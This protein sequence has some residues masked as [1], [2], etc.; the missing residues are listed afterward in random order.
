MYFLKERI[1][2]IIKQLYECIYVERTKLLSLRFLEGRFNRVEE[3]KTKSMREFGA[4]EFWGGPEYHGWFRGTGVCKRND[5]QR[6]TAVLIS[7]DTEGWDVNNPQFL[8]FINGQLRQGIDVNHQ[9]AYVMEELVEGESFQIDL[10]A[11]S[12]FWGKRCPIQI[13]VVEVDQ[14]T[15]K[16]YLDLLLAYQAAVLEDVENKKRIDTLNFLNEAVNLLDLRNPHNDSYGAG[17]ENACQYV[18]EN[19]YCFQA[20]CSCPT[21]SCIGHTHIDVAWLW[22][23]D[24]TRDK[25]VRS[26]ST[27]LRLME[28][29]PE[30]QF[31]SSQP[32][33]YSFL[34]VDYPEVY[35][36][37]CQRVREG[38][39]E[40]EGSMWVEADCN[41]PSGE[42]LV[43]QI[44]FGKKFFK[45]EFGKDNRILW[46]P[47]VFGYSAALP[48]IMKKSGIDYF[49]TTKISWNQY[50]QVPYDTFM[51]RGIDGSEVL[52]HFITTPHLSRDGFTTEYN[53][54][55]NPF[56][57]KGAWT[58]YQQKNIN[59]DVLVG[60]GFGDGG[61]GTTPLM[62]ENIRRLHQGLVDCPKAEQCLAGEYFQK[63]ENTVKGNRFLPHWNGELYFELHRGSL[64]SVGKNKR[65]NRK[66]E[67]LLHE[68][69]LLGG[70]ALCQGGDY[71]K[72]QVDAYWQTLLLNQFHDIIPGT[73]IEGVYQDSDEQY[74][75]LFSSGETLKTCL[76]G[77]LAQSVGL[78]KAGVFV[79]NSLS[80]V[81]TE[82]ASFPVKDDSPN[83]CVRNEVGQVAPCQIMEGKAYFI[84]KD[85]PSMG[86]ATYTCEPSLEKD[87]ESSLRISEHGF[88][89]AVFI[90]E[91]D[92][93]GAL[94]RLYD[95]RAQRE[96]LQSGGKGNRLFAYE[97]KPMRW[98]NW[99]VDI[100]HLEK[101]WEVNEQV[102]IRV[103]E[104]GPVFACLC[105]DK[106]FN[107]STIHQK[108]WI[109]QDIPR[110][111][112]ETWVDWKENQILLKTEFDLNL[113]FSKASFDIQ[114][115]NIERSSHNN[116]SWDVAQFEVCGHKW[117]DVSEE[118]YGVSLLNDCK[119]GHRIKEGQMQLSLIKSGNYPNKS[120]DR[121][122]HYFT[123]S[124]FPHLETWRAA[125]TAEQAHSLN[126]PLSVVKLENASGGDPASASFFSLNCKNVM[127]D[128]VKPAENGKGLVLRF[129]EYHN[130]TTRVC[131]TYRLGK[132]QLTACDLL[133]N[134]LE[135]PREVEG[136]FDFEIKPYE[137]KTFY[138][139]C[140]S[141]VY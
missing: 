77:K 114:F 56:S 35:Q 105:V 10:K 127:L 101:G 121:E 30:Y 75:K 14:L 40:P 53:G 94:S 60:Y 88:E 104:V 34:K 98:D 93:A 52:A 16:L 15:R 79:W 2:V 72:N 22:R 97:D 109:Y 71:P 133:E 82:M 138:L 37:V 80:F 21:V 51:W 36:E 91:L 110:I 62:I 33:L 9:E 27:V 41:L 108:I 76:L 59:A 106:I 17:I 141:A 46:L 125:N 43:R 32:Q 47:D 13:E 92:Q 20:E 139:E 112:F 48:Q 54:D 81:R 122:K 28:E 7:T 102:Q 100:F 24:Q 6:K 78:H 50:N 4:Q 23:L 63:L 61:G 58:R 140:L 83:L 85:I 117:A 49:M 113:H 119:Y 129:Y 42:S 66:G 95:K 3:V 68:L 69:E 96:V 116:T 103:A 130:R 124:L 74:S 132:C 86:Y 134:Q 111:D 1:E 128:T 131:V 126:Y 87:T 67:V 90:A 39:W 136:H 44:L 38:R 55:T 18:E 29:Y 5:Q 31:M 26:F 107:Q 19:L 118:G 8:L 57:I 89:N 64:T 120:A 115:G 70:L 45:E 99:D 12:G 25:V 11:Y 123:Y 137:I 65:N 73:A 135:E 84:A